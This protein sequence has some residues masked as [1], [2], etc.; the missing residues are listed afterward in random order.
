VIRFRTFESLVEAEFAAGLLRSAGIPCEAR[1]RSREPLQGEPSVWIAH[2]D[3]LHAATETLDEP[4]KPS[5]VA[6]SCATCRSEN[7]PQ[8]DAC[9]SCGAARC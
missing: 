9:W 5:G 8:F 1:D 7:E 3:D 4:P 2:Q 6:W